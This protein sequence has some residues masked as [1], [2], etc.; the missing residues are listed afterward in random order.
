MSSIAEQGYG[1][2]RR[3]TATPR[4]VEHKV[5]M[6]IAGELET[7]DPS[8][9]HGYR[10]LAQAIHRNTELWTAFA[11]DLSS[12]A[13]PLGAELKA[14]LISLANF[15]INHGLKVLHREADVQ[16]LI[17]VNRT[18]AAGIAQAASREAA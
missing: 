5:L 3:E 9:P 18:V 10:M 2:V 12:E 13:N 1:Q 17:N 8:T 4:T 14:G 7:A 15:S 11:A 16:A 6:S